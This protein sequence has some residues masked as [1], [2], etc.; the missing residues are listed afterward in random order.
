MIFRT[1]RLQLREL[2]QSDFRDLAEIL[3]DSLVTHMYAHA[4]TEKDVQEWLDRQRKRYRESGL[5]LWAM[6]LQDTGAMIGQAGLTLQPYKNTRIPEIGYLLKKE[7]RHRGY[8]KEAAAGCRDYA[9][10][11]LNCGKVYSIIRADNIPSIHVAEKIGMKK[12]DEFVPR[13]YGS[14]ALHVLY[15]LAKTDFEAARIELRTYRQE[16]CEEI[17]RLFYDTVHSV[18]ARD[19]TEAQLFAWAN[20][21]PD[22]AAWNES[23]LAHYT[24]VAVENESITGF[25]DI[26][27]DGYLDRL[28]VR[29]DR[30]GRGIAGRLCDSLEQKFP[31]RKIITHA[32]ITARPFFESRGYRIIREQQVERNGILLTNFVMEKYL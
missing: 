21:T 22:L 18:N 2:Q 29:K 3:Q 10:R 12:E 27:P 25:G 5:G 8:A 23:F 30:Q 31:V 26:R 13:Y 32:S 19:Y 24:L 14:N 28:Y 6:I 4:F 11:Q 15:S 9:F 20:G 17:S 1:K 16:D 7:Y